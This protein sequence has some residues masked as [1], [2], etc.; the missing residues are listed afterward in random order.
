MKDKST[1][2]AIQP[3]DFKDEKAVLPNFFGGVMTGSLIIQFVLPLY[4]LNLESLATELRNLPAIGYRISDHLS[5]DANS[6]DFYFV[7]MIFTPI[8]SLFFYFHMRRRYTPRFPKSDD[9]RRAALRVFL[10][11]LAAGL[12]CFFLLSL[13]PI[14]SE[15]GR[16][17][18]Y[19]WILFPPFIPILSTLMI[20]VFAGSILFRIPLTK[21]G[22]QK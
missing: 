7:S 10:V 4:V 17:F 21:K 9:E 8:F 3:S 18:R 20:P 15:S 12:A 11:A 22:K 13:A 6:V 2:R 16:A 1:Y 19:S 14:F 5:V